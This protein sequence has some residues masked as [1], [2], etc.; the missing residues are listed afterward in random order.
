MG[1][2]PVKKLSICD[3]T[4]VAVINRSWSIVNAYLCEPDDIVPRID[5]LHIALEIVK[6][7]TPQPVPPQASEELIN[8][9]L[10][11]DDIPKNGDGL[12]RFKEFIH[13]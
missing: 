1:R 4:R 2:K 9:M 12:H 10:T 8:S 13:R 5:K 11:F 3:M 7:T 6:R